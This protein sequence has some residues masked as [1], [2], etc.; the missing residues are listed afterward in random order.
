MQNGYSSNLTTRPPPAAIVLYKPDITLLD[1]LFTTLASD[2]HR[3]LVFVNGPINEAAEGLIAGLD[4]AL[5]IRSAENQGLGLALNR[6]VEAARDEGASRILLLDQDSSPRP[7]LAA[8]LE[9]AWDRYAAGGSRLAAIGPRLVPPQQENYR[10]LRY[11]WRNKAEGT[12]YFT[13]TSG[14]LVSIAAWKDIGPF[15]ADYFIDGIDVEW[16]LRAWDKGYTCAVAMDVTLEHRWGTPVP[17]D[18]ISKPQI[19]RYP[20]LRCFFY[21]RNN[22]AMLRLQHV[23]PT[24]KLKSA[25][26]LLAQVGLLLISRRFEAGTARLVWRAVSD[27]WRGRLGAVSAGYF[28]STS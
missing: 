2:G 3:L 10:P 15:R 23:A 9:G 19:L 13:P 27:G 25:M 5:V 22:V 24:W 26:H 16:G 12:V 7:G 14:S 4:N 20:K 28:A 17:A 11:V 21:I 18:E 1:H 8:A 6:L